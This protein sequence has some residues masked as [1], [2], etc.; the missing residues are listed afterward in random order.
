MTEVQLL[1]PSL[2]KRFTPLKMIFRPNSVEL[3][4]FMKYLLGFEDFTFKKLATS[5]DSTEASIYRYFEN[6]LKF[7]LYLTTLYWRWIDYL[8][9]YKTHFIADP[10]ERLKE[11]IRIITH[12]NTEYT[13]IAQVDLRRLRGIVLS[14]SD[15][16]Y[17]TKQVD[18][19]NKE[20]L[21]RSYKDLCY[22]I[23]LVIQDINPNYPYSRAIVSTIMEAANQQIYFAK[24]LPSL[25]ELKVGDKELDDQVNDFLIETL[26]KL[27]D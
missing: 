6:K 10:K 9:D 3:G 22:K 4:S 5:I 2:S 13:E 21:F 15:K 14:E 19:I 20:G 27:I 17:L 23:A 1:I 8:I 26:F 25:T 7:L 11:I 18:E 12:E 24:H 16:T